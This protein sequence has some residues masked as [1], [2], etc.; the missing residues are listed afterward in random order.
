MGE[1]D[2]FQRLLQ[3]GYCLSSKRQICFLFST[4]ELRVELII[5]FHLRH[6]YLN[7]HANSFLFS[8]TF[9]VFT[10]FPLPRPHPI[11]IYPNMV[12]LCPAIL[13]WMASICTSRWALCLSQPR[14]GPRR[15]ICRVCI[16]VLVNSLPSDWVWAMGSTIRRFRR[17]QEREARVF[18]PLSPSLPESKVLPWRQL[19]AASPQLL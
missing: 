16:N 5:L 3:Y 1:K 19:M 10:P 13:C 17:W 11:N 4:S 18:T 7:I 9:Q 12:D 6:D 8:F 15:L 14:S 2:V